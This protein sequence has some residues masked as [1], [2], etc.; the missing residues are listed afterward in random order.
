MLS[1]LEKYKPQNEGYKRY[2]SILAVSDC[3]ITKKII[4]QQRIGKFFKDL[5]S[6]ITLHERKL[7][8]MQ[9]FKK[10]LM[11]LLLTGIVRVL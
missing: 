2:Y 10:A 3:F 7:E 4:E 11:Q 8:E 5:D 1:L 6:F 9:K